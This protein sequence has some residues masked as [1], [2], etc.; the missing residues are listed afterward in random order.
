MAKKVI[1]ETGKQERYGVIF[2]ERKDAQ[3]GKLH[4]KQ[5]MFNSSEEADAFL[6]EL[7]STKEDERNR[8]IMDQEDKESTHVPFSQYAK[9]WFYDEH[10]YEVSPKTFKV[11]Q[12]L[13]NKHILPYL[14][15]MHLHEIT[16]KDISGLYTQK[17]RESYSGGTILGIQNL[18]VTLFRS[19]INKGYIQ[20]NPM[21]M[22]VIKKV[23]TQSRIPV[24]LSDEEIKRLIEVANQED[25]GMLYKFA[26]STGLRLAEILALSWSDID[27]D[28]EEIIVG[29]TVDTGGYGS[30]N[31][32]KIRSGNRKA[33][34][35][36]HL[37]SRLQKHKDE[38]KMM[39]DKP[40]EGYDN[41][42]D[43]V[44]PKKG[45]GIQRPSTVHTRFNRLIDKADI[46]RISF[47][48]LRRTHAA[49]LVKAGVSIDVVKD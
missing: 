27:F 44:F 15:D 19:A 7:G 6:E 14:G 41:E 21:S 32:V 3:T 45:G 23:S 46:R 1:I 31:I 37:I 20:K 2:D 18:L 9:E 30:Q 26:I 12:V 17:E 8:M 4:I 22:R 36:S 24:I 11:K 34:M 49:L 33:M 47:H 39:K 40:N 5:K 10:S 28:K 13:L 29:K 25:E 16:E 38:Q 48:D 43:L 42:I 35:P